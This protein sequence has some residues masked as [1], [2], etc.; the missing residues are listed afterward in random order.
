M[1]PKY[2]KRLWASLVPIPR[3]KQPNVMLVRLQHASTVHN[4]C[5]SFHSEKILDKKQ[6]IQYY[7]FQP[8][9]TLEDIVLACDDAIFPLPQSNSSPIV[10]D[11]SKQM[12]EICQGQH[13]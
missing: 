2:S 13:K 9:T 11:S 6:Q 8:K 7:N 1:C 5:Y 10:K 12:E 4:T 3:T